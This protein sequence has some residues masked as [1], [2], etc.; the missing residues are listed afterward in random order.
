MI[1]DKEELLM[2]CAVQNGFFIILFLRY[3][4]PLFLSA[5]S[6][7]DATGVL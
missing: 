2:G 6:R 5:H 4:P 3:C 1:P 7:S